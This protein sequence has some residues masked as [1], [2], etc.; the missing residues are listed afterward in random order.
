MNY[1]F[2]FF[3][4]ILSFCLLTISCGG[5]NTNSNQSDTKQDYQ[6]TGYPV[7]DG[8]TE[9]IFDDPKNHEL[10]YQRSKAYVEIEA[11]DNAISDMYMAMKIDSLQPK[12][13]THLADVF[14]NY[15][16][17]SQALETLR[18]AAERFPENKTILLNY[19]ELCITLKQSQKGIQ[20]IQKILEQDA[21]NAQAYFLMGI[22][23]REQGDMDRAKGA[24]RRV[25]DIDPEIV[26]AY[27]LLGEL[28]EKDDPK[29]ALQY[30]NNAITI[31]PENINALHSKA[32]FLQNNKQITEALEIYDHMNNLAP[33][34]IPAFLNAGI[35]YL[36]IKDFEKAFE[37][38]NIIVAAEP[39]SHIGYYYR[40]LTQIERG[41]KDLAKAD[42]QQALNL[43][44]DFQRAKDELNRLK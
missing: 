33:E 15:Y 32:F 41:N 9:K 7:V 10:L 1:R 12:Y 26:D 17:S 24:F 43:K 28:H 44:S 36:E 20:I 21:E 5:P 35:L 16:R 22:L 30:L 25:V 4:G 37:Q 34:Y 8:L 23:M 13:Y 11:Y 14:M 19:A 18:I 39:T 3:A 27:L 2:L 31:E 42:F 40:G 6:E 38:F 29:I